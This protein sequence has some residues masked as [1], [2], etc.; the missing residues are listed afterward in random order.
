VSVAK[1]ITAIDTAYWNSKLDSSSIQNFV[2]LT[3]AQT[4]AGAKTFSS[5]L[6]VNG[7]TVG[8]GG[9]AIASNTA[10][11][12]S[13][14]YSNT[15]GGYNA[16]NGFYALRLNTTG[17][18]NT[19]NGGEALYS[20]TTGSVNTA[21]GNN[22]LYS[23]TTGSANTA[24]GRAALFFN[25]TG[26]YNTATGFAAL[27]TNTTGYENT[28]TGVAALY[29]NTTGNRNTALGYNADV[30]SNNLSNATA[31]GN[32]ATVSASNRVRI[33][34][35][36]VSR[37]G[38]QVAWTNL[39]DGRIKENV[40]EA[41]PGLSFISQLRPVTYTLNTRKQDEITMQA[42]PDSIKE[43]RM[44]S[45]K[46]YLKSSSIVRTGFIAQEVE[47]AA[48]KVGFDFDGVSAPE[49]ETDLYGIR[50][51]EFVVPLVKAMQEQQEMIGGQ[52]A[53]ITE[54]KETTEE[55][56]ATIEQQKNDYMLLL[57]R[58]EALEKE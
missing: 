39:S 46:E 5:D 40:Q 37:I 17:N 45:D 54:L 56:Q 51:A 24:N 31:L 26:Y 8:K 18:G 20:N 15:T 42:M 55:Q 2:D 50:Y 21:N 29:D 28:A 4:V 48:E 47:A 30:S 34:N 38:G 22:A 19:A 14:L 53:T 27:Y 23:N 10:I 3:T 1:G 9:G 25:T 16:A 57:K 13:A 32:N 7:I 43:K 44:L 35:S 6:T 12:D 49:N 41:V 11:G 33:G 52:Q 58:I 36:S